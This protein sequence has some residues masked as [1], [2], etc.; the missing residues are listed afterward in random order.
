LPVRVEGLDGLHPGSVVMRRGG[1]L[2]HGR[3]ANPII[4]PLVADL[5]GQTAYYGQYARLEP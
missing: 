4:A 2:A 3:S 5:G 1:W